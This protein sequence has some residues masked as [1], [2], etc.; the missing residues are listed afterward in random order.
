METNWTLKYLRCGLWALVINTCTGNVL[1]KRVLG[2]VK[3]LLLNNNV[4]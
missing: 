1:F 3:E 2:C 4:V